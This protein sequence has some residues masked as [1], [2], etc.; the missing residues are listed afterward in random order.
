MGRGV[1][2]SELRL[3]HHG[4]VPLSARRRLPACDAVELVHLSLTSTEFDHRRRRKPP[5]RAPKAR[6]TA[7]HFSRRRLSGPPFDAV[8]GSVVMSSPKPS[9]A[10]NDQSSPP[11]RQTRRSEAARWHPS[12]STQD[13]PPTS[14]DIAPPPVRKFRLVTGVVRALQERTDEQKGRVVSFKVEH[15]DAEGRAL[16]VVPVEIRGLLFHGFRPRDWYSRPLEAWKGA[17]PARHSEC[18]HGR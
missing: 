4:R 9:G 6:Y 17:A 7:S 12:G 15:H 5:R 18:E 16:Q 2:R 14:R 1:A 8:E 13:K 11:P 10:D 3:T